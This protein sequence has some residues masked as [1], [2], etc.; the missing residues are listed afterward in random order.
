MAAN[1]MQVI[2]GRSV[3]NAGDSRQRTTTSCEL[4]RRSSASKRATCDRTETAIL[5]TSK[6][7]HM[8]KLTSSQRPAYGRRAARASLTQRRSKKNL[9]VCS[10]TS[11]AQPKPFEAMREASFVGLGVTAEVEPPES[12]QSMLGWQR[13]L[14]NVLTSS[15]W[16]ALRFLIA[17]TLLL[18][19]GFLFA[20]FPN[21]APP[22]VA[23]MLVWAN[24]ITLLGLFASVAAAA[25]SVAGSVAV[26]L[27]LRF[28]Q[29]TKDPDFVELE[30]QQRAAKL[31]ALGA[32][33][34]N[35]VQT[36]EIVDATVKAAQ[37]S[38]GVQDTEE[39]RES[40]R[41]SVT[42]LVEELVLQKATEVEEILSQRS[43][44]A[45]K[46]AIMEAILQMKSEVTEEARA[47]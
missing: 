21:G 1:A 25:I 32:S 4:S 47:T 34:L 44:V 35:P 31:E 3:E 37:V 26:H 28:R 2:R 23:R 8:K 17:L 22:L 33:K 39:L 9:Q 11:D 6:S 13:S 36:S 38:A 20:L 46:E 43:I 15:L 7:K 41:I 24:T 29:A 40:I 14:V 10:A 42:R 5:H 30:R 19:P 27:L 45:A 12:I 18:V 16:A